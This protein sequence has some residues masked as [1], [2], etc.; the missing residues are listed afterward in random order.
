MKTFL[1]GLIVI[2]SLS[3]CSSKSKTDSAFICPDCGKQITDGKMYYKVS[4]SIQSY[5][6]ENKSPE[7]Y[8]LGVVPYPCKKCIRKY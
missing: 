6:L 8:P 1:L 2:S 7:S 5:S 3:Q 4:G